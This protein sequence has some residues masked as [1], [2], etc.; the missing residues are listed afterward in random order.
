MSA[1]PVVKRLRTNHPS[2]R[3]PFPKKTALPLIHHT[4]PIGLAFL[5]PDCRYL[6]INQRLRLWMT[7][8]HP[9]RGADGE[10]VGVNVAAEEITER[11]HAETALEA[12]E[13]GI[14]AVA[15]QYRNYLDGR[16][17]RQDILV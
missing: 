11:K 3:S 6:Q 12:S 14:P 8:W 1:T 2:A 10:I 17:Q 4:S 16:S 5:S 7:Y 9:L 13:S 15:D